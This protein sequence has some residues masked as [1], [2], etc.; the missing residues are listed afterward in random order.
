MDSAKAGLLILALV[1][2]TLAVGVEFGANWL[3]ETARLPGGTEVKHPGIG[4]SD[5]AILDV[6]LLYSA[7]LLGS[8]LVAP[9]RPLVG[10]IQGIAT[11]VIS[12]VSLL[13][14]LVLLWA[15]VQFL[16]L[17]VTLLLAPPLGTVAYMV[18]WG[19]FDT[20][21]AARVLSLAMVLKL[22][23]VVLLLLSS[24]SIL[25]NRGL[26]L[27]LI[28]SIGMTYLLAFLHAFPPGVLVSITDAVGAILACCLAI[29]WAARFLISSIPAV[30]KAV[31]G[32]VPST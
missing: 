17:M 9:L 6:A 14:A 4:L 5:L 21:K 10:R 13:A 18:A 1:F 16:V 12:L 26:M 24:P 2:L 27:L 20:T 19:H 28:C 25:R 22:I 8:D 15:A 23:G 32:L 11:F 29:V 3:V 31:T 30:V 7:L